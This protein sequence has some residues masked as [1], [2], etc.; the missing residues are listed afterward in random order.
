MSL[1]HDFIL[2][3]LLNKNILEDFDFYLK[4]VK[5]ENVNDICTIKKNIYLEDDYI[6]YFYDTFLRIKS[7]APNN[8]NITYGINRHGITL[9]NNESYD[10]FYEVISGWIKIFSVAPEDINLKGEYCCNNKN[11]GNYEIPQIK[12]NDIL[13]KLNDLI[14]IIAYLKEENYYII[15]LGI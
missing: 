12:K 10:T 5:K 14:N 9:F 11:K 8:P 7:I 3:N 2:V 4:L 13:N 1:I 15:H 6:S